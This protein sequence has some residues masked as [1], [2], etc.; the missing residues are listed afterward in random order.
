VITGV[1][2]VD[3]QTESR[4]SVYQHLVKNED[5]LISLLWPPFHNSDPSPGYIQ[6]Y[7]EGLRENGGQY[8]HAAAWVIIAEAMM[9]HGNRAHELFSMINPINHTRTEQ[10]LERYITE[11]Y[12]TCG[13]VY[14][15]PPFNG[16]GGWSWYTGSSGWLYRAAIENIL[17]IKVLRGKSF[18]LDPCI[19]ADWREF[20][21][22]Y[23]CKGG[24]YKCLVLNPNGHETGV[25]SVKRNGRLIESKEIEL[26]LERGE[27]CEILVE[28]GNFS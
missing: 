5:K 9:G 13:D 11:P 2:R 12:V 8:T 19:P 24:L 15:V 3:L 26:D 1:A 28:M 7:P 23:R 22:D 18:T 14:S 6:G 21:L 10:E 27:S 20:K 17:G 16:R 4:K 25:L